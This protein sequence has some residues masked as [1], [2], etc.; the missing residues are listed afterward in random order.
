[1]CSTPFRFALQLLAASAMWLGVVL[2]VTGCDPEPGSTDGAVD[3]G[4]DASDDG[5]LD[6]GIVDRA[7]LSGCHYDCFGGFFCRDGSVYQ[8]TPAPIGCRD[9]TGACPSL[10]RTDVVCARG[11]RE[12]AYGRLPEEVCE[13]NVPKDVGSPCTAPEHCTPGRTVP[14]GFGGNAP[15]ALD[16][17]TTTSLCVLGVAELCNGIDDDGDGTT[18]EDCTITARIVADVSSP[19]RSSA[20]D[21]AFSSDRIALLRRT[22][23]DTSGPGVALEIV[24]PDGVALTS[25]TDLLYAQGVERE[26]GGWVLLRHDGRGIVDELVRLRD[27]ATRIVVPLTDATRSRY[28]AL[29]PF[30]TSYLVL[31]LTELSD[32]ITLS[33]HDGTTGARTA[34]GVLMTTPDFGIH[35]APLGA[36]VLIVSASFRIPIDAFRITPPLAVTMPTPTT[37]SRRGRIGGLTILAARYYAVVEDASGAHVLGAFDSVTGEWTELTPLGTLL[38]EAFT[39]FPPVIAADGENLLVSWVAP[40]GMLRTIALDA[41]GSRIGTSIIEVG[42]PVDGLW[43]GSTSA[44]ARV[45]VPTATGWL[46]VA[47]GERRTP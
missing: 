17:D 27:D 10:L 15:L 36:D 12:F 45:I 14:D 11:C 26:P 4:V 13:E 47:P 30:G 9:W 18:D 38:P 46:F 35:H 39:S 16:C 19:P 23:I 42:V 33:L 31:G 2:G 43:A 24:S 41:T 6:G 8:E 28:A 3:S 40:D 22:M 7:D 37:P 5:A 32:G 20:S 44:G 21:V 1:M 25:H 34:T 29:V